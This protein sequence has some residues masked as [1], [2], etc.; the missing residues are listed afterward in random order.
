MGQKILLLFEVHTGKISGRIMGS[1]RGDNRNNDGFRVRVAPEAPRLAP[2][3][4]MEN[5]ELRWFLSAD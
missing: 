1:L 4:I 5:Y 2:G 3:S